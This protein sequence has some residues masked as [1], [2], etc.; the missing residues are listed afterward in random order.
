MDMMTQE[1]LLEL[2]GGV[3]P[4][5]DHIIG[6]TKLV[7]FD[8]IKS[9]VTKALGFPVV[10]DQFTDDN[11][12]TLVTILVPRMSTLLSD[13]LLQMIEPHMPIGATAEIES[14]WWKYWWRRLV[15]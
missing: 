5:G 3:D 14:D 12:L 2:F 7:T 10:V 4:R 1:K 9:T 13:C 15:G 6:N 11:G 8:E